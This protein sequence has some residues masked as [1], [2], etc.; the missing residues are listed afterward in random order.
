[1]IETDVKIHDKYTVEFKT[2]F[3]TNNKPKD[4]NEF[5]INTWIFIPGS[6]DINRFTYNKEQFYLDT[7]TNIRLITPVYTLD[8]ILKANR[9]PFPRL[10]KSIETLLANVT[11]ENEESYT[12]QIKMLM[13]IIKSSLRK[14]VQTISHEDADN[15]ILEKVKTLVINLN[16]ITSNYRQKAHLL[17]SPDI[18]DKCREYFSFGDD[19][20]GNVIEQHL[21]TLLRNLKVKSVYGLVKEPL[22]DLIEKEKNYKQEKG[23]SYIKE[24]D[25]KSNSLVILRWGI[26]KKFIESDLYLH[27]LKKQDGAFARQVYYSVAAGVAMIFAT[28][29]SFFATQRYGNFTSDLF[30]VLVVSYMLKDRIKE[31]TRYYFTAKLDKKYFDNKWK[32]SIRNQEIGWIKEGFDFIAEPS[33]PMEI[34]DLR[35]RSPLIEAENQISVEKIILYRKLVNLSRE[36][37]EKYKEYRLSGIND[38]TRFNITQFVRKMDNP[39][40]PLFLPDADNGYTKINGNKLYP[41]YFIVQCESEQSVYYKKYRLLFNKDGISDATELD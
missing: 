39:T 23:Y 41:L 24:G 38:I 9:G 28:I 27:T 4:I 26:L 32:L 29:I 19:F 2:G 11:P 30:I 5:K 13:C 8:E 3:I 34:M 12:Y 6:L 20:L 18:S 37:L 7:K 1:M 35:N 22:V 36:D 15:V 31:L 14:E 40:I 33:V 10:Q 21:F 17:H 25:D 16:Q